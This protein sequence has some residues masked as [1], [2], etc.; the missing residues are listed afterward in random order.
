MSVADLAFS[1]GALEQLSESVH[2]LR[3]REIDAPLVGGRNPFVALDW[4]SIRHLLI[5]ISSDMN[6][7]ADRGT[8]VHFA[9]RTLLDGATSLVFLDVAC[10]KPH[11]NALF[12]VVAGEMLEACEGRSLEDVPSI[13]QGVLERWRELLEQL[14]TGDVRLSVLTGAWSEL[15]F[16]R[17][18]LRRGAAWAGLWQ[19]PQGAVHDIAGPNGHIEVKSTLSRGPLV[20]EVHGLGQLDAPLTGTLLLGVLRLRHGPNDGEA[21]DEMVRSCVD[22]GAD[23]AE[24]TRLLGLLGINPG[25]RDYSAVRFNVEAALLFNVSD[26]F[27]RIVPSSLRMDVPSEVVSLSYQL[28][29]TGLVG[30]ALR[31]AAFD[32]TLR[33]IAGVTL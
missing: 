8:G 25:V 15:W 24:L 2:E 1:W 26:D 21:I 4:Q 22:S 12:D 16:V 19:G 18:L 23:H 6:V 20:V 33:A 5:P 13:C 9:K 7:S 3:A 11:L 32:A 27:P 17:E 28:D 29:L 30:R 14:A 10:L 31:G